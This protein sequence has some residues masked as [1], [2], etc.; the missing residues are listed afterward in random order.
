MLGKGLLLH[1]NGRR[2]QINLLLF[3]DDIAPVA[4]KE[5]KLC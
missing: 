1:A 4:D 5:E 2:F 3:A